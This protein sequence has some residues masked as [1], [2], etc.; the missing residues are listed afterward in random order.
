MAHVVAVIS[1]KGGTGKSSLCASIATCLAA[2]EQR[3]LCI[4]CDVG[5]RNLDIPLGMADAASIPF[6]C[7]M[8]GEYTIFDAPVHPQLPYLS[9]LTAP[10]LE[11]PESVPETL[12]GRM[13]EEA[14]QAFDWVFLDAPAGLG[15]GFQL[16]TAF[17]DTAL[18]VA[19]GDPAAMRD[20]ARTCDLLFERRADISA[21]LIVN[22]VSPRLFRRMRATIDDVMDEVGLPLIGI[23][24]DDISVTLAAAAGT[25]LILYTTQ[26]AAVASVHIARRLCGIKTPLM[27]L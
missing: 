26:G 7:V 24:P 16:A 25:P 15:A 6:S 22:R 27:R 13:V 17:A 21:R 8:R 9:L 18:V 5:L 14:A 4:D 12:F 10:M 2:E 3:V 23:V 20:A 11:T 19:G 1:G